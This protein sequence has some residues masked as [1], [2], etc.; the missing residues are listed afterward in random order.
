MRAPEPPLGAARA[1]VLE[2]VA[3][4]YSLAA[5]LAT[6]GFDVVAVRSVARACAAVARLSPALLVLDARTSQ[7]PALRV[8]SRV[9]SSG[10]A[11]PA[12]TVCA[13][14]GSHVA[15][16]LNAGADECVSAPHVAAELPA[17][18]RALLRRAYGRAD[19]H[20]SP[21]LVGRLVLHP[22]TREASRDGVPICLS[23]K[24][25][26][27]LLALLESPGRVV[28]RRELLSRVWP[29][30][31]T[32]NARTLDQHVAWLRQKVEADHRRPEIIRTVR[33]IGYVIALPRA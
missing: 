12:L 19:W 6:Q 21:I 16:A 28:E 31:A 7:V 11:I 20:P 29:E 13:P 26:G 3:Q 30:R 33:S 18:A 4:E 2:D 14:G 17:R 15:A 27:L 5:A 25:H 1:V 22:L 32:P 24:E 9:R 23:P 8:L 10:S